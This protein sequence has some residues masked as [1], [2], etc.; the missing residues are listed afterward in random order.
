MIGAFFKIIL[1]SWKHNKLITILIVL[2]VSVSLTFLTITVSSIKS[3]INNIEYFT[4]TKTITFK[5]N[6][7]TSELEKLK[8]KWKNEHLIGLASITANPRKL[9]IEYNGKISNYYVSPYDPEQFQMDGRTDIDLKNNEVYISVQLASKL[10]GSDINVENPKII[11][12]NKAYII[13]YID[14]EAVGDFITLNYKDAP[15]KN[16]E[17]NHVQLVTTNDQAI[18]VIMNDLKPYKPVLDDLETST[19]NDAHKLITFLV[20]VAV[21]LLVIALINFIQLYRYKL[22]L[23]E[24]K[25]YVLTLLGANKKAI[26]MYIYLECLG[27]CLIAFLL[28][29]FEYALFNQFIDLTVL[30][31]TFNLSIF[32]ILNIVAILI[33]MIVVSFFMKKFKMKFNF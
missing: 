5:K 25:W 6:I 4:L 26:Q 11:I 14:K 32:I 17:S 20:V 16:V 7:L 18:S 31:Q 27:L 3:Q 24:N 23:D 13:K 10:L 22:S 15:F 30:K 19:K 28:S 9:P 21:L 1:N 2:S 29:S 33:I 8:M 12:N